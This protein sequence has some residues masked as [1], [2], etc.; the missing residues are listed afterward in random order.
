M[1]IER[2]SPFATAS[3]DSVTITAIMPV[4]SPAEASVFAQRP[5]DDGTLLSR[6]DF[7]AQL[8]A[9]MRIARGIGLHAEHLNEV[10]RKS[11]NGTLRPP[12]FPLTSGVFTKG[13]E[14]KPPVA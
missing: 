9:W 3:P 5:K 13:G 14:N 7:N 8:F 2:V 6:S 1:L 10:L 11:V 12:I 4:A